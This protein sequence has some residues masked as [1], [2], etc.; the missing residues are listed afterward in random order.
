MKVYLL[1]LRLNPYALQYA[2]TR[3]MGVYLKS[4]KISW[5]SYYMS[6]IWIMTVWFNIEEVSLEKYV[7]IDL[8]P[9][10]LLWMKGK[11]LK[12]QHNWRAGRTLSMLSD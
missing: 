10:I 2:A 11:I 3:Q 1:D 7:R 6:G 5:Y 4:N 9:L 12:F 8:N